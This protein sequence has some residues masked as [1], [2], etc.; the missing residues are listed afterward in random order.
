MR[1]IKES[2]QLFCAATIVAGS[3]AFGLPATAQAG[4]VGEPS[5]VISQLKITSH[6]GQFITLYNATDGTLDMSR[7]QLEYFNSYDPDKA[8]SSRVVSLSGIV[9]PHGYFIVNNGSLTLCYQL[10]I[11]SLS[12]GFSSTAGMVKVLGLGTDIASVPM[13]EDYVG[14]SKT[15]APGAETLPA[16]S[17]AF[18]ERQPAD[19]LY[20]P[21]ITIP[22]SGSWQTV[23]PDPADAC[24]LV[25]NSDGSAVPTGLSQLLSATE[26]PATILAPNDMTIV[27]PG[28]LPPTDFGLKAPLITELLPNPVGSGNDGTDEFIELYNPND[29]VFDL[30]GF[31]LQTGTTSLHNY[32]FPS[33][34]SLEPDGF[35]AFYSADTEL[36]LSNKGGQARLL[37]PAGN[38]IAVTE[39]YDSA[40]DGLA[41][42]LANGKWYWTTR[43]TPGAGNVIAQ[44]PLA[45]TAA[46]KASPKKAG[47]A[48]KTT[49]AKKTA[50]AK[51][52]AVKSKKPKAKKAKTN[53]AAAQIADKQSAT[54]IHVWSLALVGAAALLYGAYEYRADLANRV[55]QLR[56]YWRT[57]R[58]NRA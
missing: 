25:S 35:Q 18:L 21:F 51:T 49:K 29:A 42:A 43:P 24:A 1:R 11:N 38:P 16:D 46:V 4:T 47:T 52:K 53:L 50:T 40:N 33:G 31:T 3:L 45:K 30:S 6:D 27:S 19:G 5:L 14:W 15:G 48:A 36:S 44:P 58:E 17:D 28:Q 55:Y 26:P 10:T 9:P 57:R 7:Y 39:A 12:L 54:P 32:K 8:T 34:T 22:G 13:L 56:S 41:W 20:N 37:D 23:R 2:F